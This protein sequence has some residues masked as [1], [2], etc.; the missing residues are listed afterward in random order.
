MPKSALT[1]DQQK[2]LLGGIL[3]V[4][5][6][7]AWLQFVLLPQQKRLAEARSEQKILRGQLEQLKIGLTQL[8][9]MEEEIARL[10]GEAQMPANP[11]PP[12]EQL[13]ALLE[14]ITKAARRA[15]V[16]VVG[17]KP[18]SDLDQASPGPS[19]YLEIPIFIIVE[20]GYHPIGQFLDDL[21]SSSNLLQV[22]DLS[23]MPLADDLYRHHAQILFK[24][25]LIPAGG[26]KDASP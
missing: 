2:K 21:E 18:Q 7:V 15:Q 14:E 16:R 26:G 6:V 3:A 25:Y 1:P 12:E 8:S 23:I 5:G 11:K 17:Q 24:A 13:P 22:L 9:S 10:A 19:G 20:G 4:V